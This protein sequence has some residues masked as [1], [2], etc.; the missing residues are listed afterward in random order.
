[1]NRNETY[2]QTLTVEEAAAMLGVSRGLA[3]ESVKR[4]DIPSLKIG[5]R[6]VIPRPALERMLADGAT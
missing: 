3:Y 1:M 2:K 5:K 4:G 6:I